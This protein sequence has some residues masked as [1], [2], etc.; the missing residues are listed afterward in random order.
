M[1]PVPPVCS[2]CGTTAVLVD[3]AVIYHGTSY[4]FAWKCPACPDVYVG[5]HQCTRKPLGRL[6]DAELRV[7]KMLAH[8]AFDRL[9]RRGK[10]SRSEAYHF[11][12]EKLGLPAGS[13]H[14]GE[15]DLDF[16]RRVVEVMEKV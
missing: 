14:I 6:A 7:A 11:L 13:C 16:C 3:S 8:A 4:G 2:Y 5:C 15:F 9:W 1:K 10:M 12:A